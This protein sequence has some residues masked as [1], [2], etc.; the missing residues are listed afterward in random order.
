MCT[1]EW[2]NSMVGELCLNKAVIKNHNDSNDIKI[3][4]QVHIDKH[5]INK[6]K[7]LYA[8]ECQLM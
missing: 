5:T 4:I 7:A 6:G 2:V 1:L 3:I 8:V